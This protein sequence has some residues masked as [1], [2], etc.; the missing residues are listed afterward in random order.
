M[1]TKANIGVALVIT[2]AVTPVIGII[3]H[4][5]SHGIIIQPRYV[6]KTI[7]WMFGYAMTALLSI[8][9]SSERC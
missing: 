8:G 6:L 4:L 5:K 7:H 3:L 1:K 9:P 2:F